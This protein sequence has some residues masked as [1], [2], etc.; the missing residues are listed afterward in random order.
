MMDEELNTLVYRAHAYRWPVIGWMA[1]IEN[2]RRE[3]CEAYFRTYYAPNNACLYLAGN[4]E[5]KKALALITKYFGS[6]KPGP[7]PPAVVDA[8]PQQ[9][10]ERRAQVH[11]PAQ[12][13]SIMAAFRG[14]PA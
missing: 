14:P 8:E 10:G 9:K 3:D 6:I 4:F 7:T 1:D 13:P 2:I 11:H 5:P 12:A